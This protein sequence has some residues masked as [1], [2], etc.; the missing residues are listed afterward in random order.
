MKYIFWGL[1]ILFGIPAVA[2][3]GRFALAIGIGLWLKL[4]MGLG[5][6]LDP[7]KVDALLTRI[8]P[9]IEEE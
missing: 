9:N 8:A 1:L 5:V 7:K 3:I 6:N 4:L 2:I